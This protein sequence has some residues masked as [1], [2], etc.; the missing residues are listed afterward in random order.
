MAVAAID[1]V[2]ETDDEDEDDYVDSMTEYWLIPDD[3]HTVEV[4]F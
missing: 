3:I 4:M 2:N 1:N